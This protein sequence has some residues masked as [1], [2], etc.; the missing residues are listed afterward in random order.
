MLAR[1]PFW[2][3]LLIIMVALYLVYNPLG[4]SLTH[5]WLFTDPTAMLPFKIL[6][7]LV[8][9]TIIGLV[10]HGTVTS[11]SAFG[12]IILISLI[13]TTLWSAH[14]AIG[15]DLMSPLF[16]GWAAQPII[17]LIL[18]VGWQWPKI[19]R[20]STGAVSISDPDTPA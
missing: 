19:W 11:M 8:V 4:T 1:I 9:L 7:S 12:F 20:R 18:T 14:A 5:M 17:A 2:G 16:W 3:W 6:G 15:F 13:G 10:I